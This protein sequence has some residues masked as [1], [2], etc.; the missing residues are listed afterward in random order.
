[1]DIKASS[2]IELARALGLEI[3]LVPQAVVP[4]VETL[5]RSS[6]RETERPRAKTAGHKDAPAPVQEAHRA[7]GR[8]AKDAERLSRALGE[9]S[10]LT[11]LADAAR[12]LD[13]MHLT[14][15]YAQQ[16]Y[17]TLKA[18]VLPNDAIKKALEAQCSVAELLKRTD[19]A[20]SLRTATQA[21]DSLR[22]IR[23]ALAHGPD[24]PIRRSLPAYRLTDED[25]DA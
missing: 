23:N 15:S 14:T 16:A 4:A 25:D 7:L 20:A 18:V 19:I 2:L 5:S 17:E 3:M 24:A 13:R 21:A 22:T 9:I 10:E 6:M 8:I 1:M 11:R 12:E